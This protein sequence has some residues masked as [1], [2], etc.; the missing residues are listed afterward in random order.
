MQDQYPIAHTQPWDDLHAPWCAAAEPEFLPPPAPSP[1]HSLQFTPHTELHGGFGSCA[2]GTPMVVPSTPTGSPR[3]SKASLAFDSMFAS[4]IASGH[5]HTTDHW[6]GDAEALP[7]DTSQP[8]KT[9]EQED[10]EARVVAEVREA[11]RQAG[12]LDWAEGADNHISLLTSHAKDKSCLFGTADEVH[13]EV[14]LHGGK[15]VGF[16]AQRWCKP[17]VGKAGKRL[18]GSTRRKSAAGS[19][20]RGTSALPDPGG[21][22][23]CLDAMH[24]RSVF[25][26]LYTQNQAQSSAVC[27][28]AGNMI[29]TFKPPEEEHSYNG[30]VMIV[31]DRSIHR[32]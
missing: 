9:K 15:G 5:Q 19:G 10:E 24:A 29:R 2:M 28:F 32:L 11:A 4:P 17:P 7:L 30:A 25:V 27:Y 6:A 8:W 20:R 13:A 3:V 16:G 31:D 22:G 12:L 14:T 18:Y 21:R 26:L 1:N 23:V